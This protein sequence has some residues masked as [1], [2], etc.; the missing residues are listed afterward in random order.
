MLGRDARYLLAAVQAVVACEWLVSGA[1]KVLSGTFPQGLAGALD[2][3]T[4][5]N[6]SDMPNP[7]GWY[8]AF[9]HA[10]VLPHSVLFG[11]LIE[12]AELVIGAAL[13]AGAVLLVGQMPA[14]GAPHHRLA[15]EVLAVAAVAALAGTFLCVNFHFWMGDGLIPT[16]NPAH[17][18]DE[19]IDLDTL[20]P[21]LCLIVAIANFRLFEALA[22][23]SAAHWVRAY[24]ARCARYAHVA[25]QQEGSRA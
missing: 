6:M 22:G 9:L 7:N 13:L 10:V 15:T 11:Y 12:S 3:S 14:A 1:N 19:G 8:V 17:P 24:V 20:L 4:M 5:S 18:F 25:R 2:M 23:I 16:L 21:P